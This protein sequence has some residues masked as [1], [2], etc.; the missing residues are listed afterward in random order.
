[1]AIALSWIKAAMNIVIG[2]SQYYYSLTHKCA[3]L[4][5]KKMI[6]VMRQSR[7]EVQFRKAMENK[8]NE[9]KTKWRNEKKWYFSMKQNLKGSKK[10]WKECDY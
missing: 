2:I 8:E 4:E 3:S 6:V 9:W 1:M 10:I 5:T 7:T